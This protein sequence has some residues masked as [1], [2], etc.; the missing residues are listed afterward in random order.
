MYF[1]GLLNKLH[2]EQYM[3]LLSFKLIDLCT[4]NS[5]DTYTREVQNWIGENV[6]VSRIIGLPW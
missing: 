6:I 3:T 2:S 4:V 1:R 5:R